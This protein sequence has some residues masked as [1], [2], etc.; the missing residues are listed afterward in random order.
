[1][2]KYTIG[3]AGLFCG[4]A[5]GVAIMLI[6]AKGSENTLIDLKSNAQAS[7]KA[8][9]E[10]R[11]QLDVKEQT[12]TDIRL[13]LESLQREKAI[14]E[15]KAEEA[16]KKAIEQKELIDKAQEKMGDAFK[17]LSGESGGCLVTS[18]PAS[19]LPGIFQ[20]GRSIGA[21]PVGGWI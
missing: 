2:K 3:I 4:L 19:H 15:T 12:I 10:V 17:A 14:A 20:Q 1:M 9:E 16:D 7:E 5:V 21:G 13:K 11:R 18:G 8:L 6:K